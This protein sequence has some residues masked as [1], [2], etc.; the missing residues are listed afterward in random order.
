MSFTPLTGCMK[1]LKT[2]YSV[3]AADWAKA[4]LTTIIAIKI[5]QS[6]IS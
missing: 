3:K 5:K 2:F 1:L 4:T 6:L